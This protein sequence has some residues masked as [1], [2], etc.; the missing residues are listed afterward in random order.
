VQ[1][2]R[3]SL[4]QAR[5]M[6]G[7]DHINTLAI[8]TNLGR[9]LEAQGSAAEAERLLRDASARLDPA[10]ASQRV[11]Y[12]NAQSGLG[13][14]LVAQGRAAEARDLLEPAVELARR[15]LGA[16]NIRTA[17]AELALGRALLATEEYATAKPLLLAAQAYFG[18]QRE[19][20]PYF[21]AQAA[22]ALAELRSRL[23]AD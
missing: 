8:T 1:Y 20:Q 12:V 17:D 9:A 2:F 3:E 15:E 16:E 21:A 10:N 18:K 19:R 7:E 14:A 6:L 22:A 11:W 4:G 23:P 5:R 13:L